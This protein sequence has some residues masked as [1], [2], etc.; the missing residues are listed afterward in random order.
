MKMSKDRRSACS[1]NVNNCRRVILHYYV[2]LMLNI[3]KCKIIKIEMK[4][5]KKKMQIFYKKL[6][7]KKEDRKNYWIRFNKHS[8]IMIN[9][10][11]VSNIA[12]NR[13]NNN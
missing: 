10:R 3:W 4:I 9:K 13:I 1:R 12:R 8:L 6:D 7:S 2:K 5:W 11:K